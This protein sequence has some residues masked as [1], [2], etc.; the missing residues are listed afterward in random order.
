MSRTA[1]K[2]TAERR[3]KAR[4]S[5]SRT[6]TSR[7]AKSAK[8]HGHASP[9]KGANAA[10]AARATEDACLHCSKRLE[11]GNRA[12]FV[13]EEVGRVFCSED[14]IAAYFAPEIA[15]LEK[16]F[17]RRLSSEDLTGE[18]REQLAHLRW[19]TLQEPD[20]VW[21][22]KTLSGDNRYA[23]ISE[24]QPGQDRI[25]CVCLCLFL[26]G[27]P[28]FL[29]LSFVTRDH[30]LVAHYRRGER[31]QW[32]RS[33]K[34]GEGT[35]E[36]RE[37]PAGAPGEEGGNP[38][39]LKVDRLAEPWT[40]DET[41][42][43]RLTSERSPEDVPPEEWGLYQ[44]CLEET[45]QQPDEVWTIRPG[46][47]DSPALYHFIRHYPDESPA[48]WYV[49][50]A[51]ETADDDE[52]IEILDAFPTKDRALVDRYRTGEQEVGEVEH[53][54]SAARVVH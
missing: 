35:K 32:V 18:E 47:Q 39:L 54:P 52:Q 10:R 1:T 23:L 49:I 13:E 8:A 22:E 20:E 37:A 4:G 3:K 9:R 15:R 30:D 48:V 50:I 43:A 16:E 5:H 2:R 34:S 38:D 29:F 6:K 25:W 27:E 26:R 7:A 40:E 46:G 11:G 45:L 12:L 19:I 44:S 28:S 17:F 21:R 31:M 51:R 24:F 42:L 36:I 53:K 14:C 33:E 41:F